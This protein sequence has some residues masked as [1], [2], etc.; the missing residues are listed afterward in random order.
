MRTHA[1][2]RLMTP[3]LLAFSSSL[4]GAKAQAAPSITFEE[5]KTACVAA[6]ALTHKPSLSLFQVEEKKKLNTAFKKID[7]KKYC[8]C[9]FEGYERVF[10][11]EVYEKIIDPKLPT[12]TA[13]GMT[14][15]D[16]NRKMSEVQFECFGKLTDR[17]GLAP[18]SAG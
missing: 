8:A 11:R 13:P 3:C 14:I 2:R 17:P 15:I 6:K 1:L 10:G 7:I 5:K 4:C 16:E 9:V 18:P 12:Y